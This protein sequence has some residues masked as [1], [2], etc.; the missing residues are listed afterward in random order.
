MIRQELLA[1]LLCTLVA[2]AAAYGLW[3]T[4]PPKCRTILPRQRL[5]AV[6]WGAAAIGFAIFNHL[7]WP[8]IV[9]R[10]LTPSDVAGNA[11][12]GPE[13]P[14]YFWILNLSV[15][16]EIATLLIGFR[17]FI[18]VL[19]YQLGLTTHRLRQNMIAGLVGW[20]MLIPLVLLI[21]IAASSV[22][23]L[24]RH[25]EPE[26]HPFTRIVKTHVLTPAEWIAFVLATVV[27]APVIE[28]LLFRGILLPVCRTSARAA[29][30]G[31]VA[32]FGIALLLPTKDFGL[33]PAVFVAVMVPGYLALW[34]GIGN[35]LSGAACRGIYS[36]A[37]VFAA[38][39]SFA[40]PTPIPLFVLGLGL[41]YLA[42]RTQSLVG[43]V[44]MHALLNGMTCLALILAYGGRT[45]EAANGKPATSAD[46]PPAVCIST[47]DPGVS[48]PR[49]TYARAIGPRRGDSTDDV[50]RPISCPSR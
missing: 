9:T 18:G 7:L 29:D 43:P 24:V 2:G 37:L 26:E 19:P 14:R 10:V 22:Y 32:A 50:T 23:V 49:F 17:V 8:A 44:V 36:T 15:V 41:G 40:W 35:W 21:N 46:S 28:E 3:R 38:S 39:H 11:G 30:V 48:N 34:H 12:I 25:A 33:W 20:L 42:Y 27:T 6:P 4:L 1:W 13:D 5:R 45:D 16:L 47:T 31:I